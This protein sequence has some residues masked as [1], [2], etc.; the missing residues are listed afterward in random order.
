MLKPLALLS[1]ALLIGC[2]SSVN[3]GLDPDRI[4][5][6]AGEEAGQIATPRERLT[7][8]LNI[9]NRETQTGHP[10]NGIQTL[11]LAR[12]TLE[13]ADKNSLTDQERLSGW[14][15]LCELARDA[16]D[17]TFAGS[18][19]DQAL[20]D[21]NRLTPEWARCEYVPGIESEVRATRGDAAAAA[22]LRTAGDWAVELKGLEIRRRAYLAFTE[23][24]FRCNDYEGARLV[25][26]HDADAAWRSDALVALADTAR[27]ASEKVGTRDWYN[28]TAIVRAPGSISMMR[29]PLR[30][31]L[32]ANPTTQPTSS[33]S[34]GK[35]L[36]FKSNYYRP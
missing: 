14:I 7:R 10:G 27:L 33:G 29:A 19:L 13:S 17:L 20:A 16:K 26:R 9:A 21:L 24:L 35:A 25:L 12:Q 22:L 23:E 15:S 28:P 30:S 2:Q 8:Q 1:L 31:D 34:F 4:L 32:D 6:M 3:S 5:H 11:K 36:D 18:A